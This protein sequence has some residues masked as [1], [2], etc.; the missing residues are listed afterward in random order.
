MHCFKS[1]FSFLKKCIEFDS[2]QHFVSNFEASDFEASNFWSIFNAFFQKEFFSYLKKLH[3]IWF[4]SVAK[5][6]FYDIT[7]SLAHLK[8]R[9]KLVT[10]TVVLAN[11]LCIY[12]LSKIYF[13]HKFLT[14]CIEIVSFD[15][16]TTISMGYINASKFHSDLKLITSWLVIEPNRSHP[17]L[18]MKISLSKNWTIR[19]KIIHVKMNLMQ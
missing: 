9:Y 1:C 10:W 11:I 18:A 6:Q 19:R 13:W 7:F 17:W 14:N 15:M 12:T 4:I 5:I 8:V 16:K 2:F 3:W